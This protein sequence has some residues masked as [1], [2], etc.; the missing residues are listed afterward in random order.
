MC[1]FNKRA[2]PFTVTFDGNPGIQGSPEVQPGDWVCGYDSADD[3]VRGDIRG[4]PDYRLHFDA[5]NMFLFSP[6]LGLQVWQGARMTCG[7]GEFLGEGGTVE[8]VWNGVRYAG[9]RNDDDD[10]WKYFVVNVEPA[11]DGAG[12]TC[13]GS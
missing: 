5:E 6:T 12:N 9:Q 11:Q 3:W 2:E 4:I 1:I 7:R 13:A 8:I 10:Y